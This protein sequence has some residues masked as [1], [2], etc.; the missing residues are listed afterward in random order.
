[1]SITQ[2]TFTA[3]VGFAKEDYFTTRERAVFNVSAFSNTRVH[4]VLYTCK[5]NIVWF[6]ILKMV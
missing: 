1:M 3:A 5:I 2:C 4:S 6:I